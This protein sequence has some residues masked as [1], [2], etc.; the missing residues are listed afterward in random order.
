MRF[1][2]RKV[3]E[4]DSTPVINST[5]TNDNAGFVPP[6]PL[7]QWGSEVSDG[8]PL[9][10]VGVQKRRGGVS[11]SGSDRFVGENNIRPCCI[12]KWNQN[13]T[14]AKPSMSQPNTGCHGPC[15][16]SKLHDLSGVYRSSPRPSQNFVAPPPE[17]EL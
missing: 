7:A 9:L 4:T 14:K 10:G 8:L 17:R 12:V 5:V 6:T 11:S 3:D 1:I 2:L 15:V 13:R 16:V